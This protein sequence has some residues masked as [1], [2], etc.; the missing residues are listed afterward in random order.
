LLWL[1]PRAADRV[2]RAAREAPWISAAWGLAGILLLPVVAALLVLSLVALPLGL[3]LVFALALVLFV[4]YTWSVWVLG[5]AIVREHG[6]VLALLAGWAIARAVGLIPVV[7]G[8]TF[9]LAAAFGLG[10]MTVAVWRARGRTPRRG[11]S[12]RRGYVELPEPAGE[13]EEHAAAEPIG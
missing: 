1:T 10:S 11:G 13:E 12:H 2:L 7:S 9:G 3:V 5:R 6:R 4:S 8:V